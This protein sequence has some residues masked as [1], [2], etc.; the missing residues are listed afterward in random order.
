MTLDSLWYLSDSVIKNITP[1]WP[2]CRDKGEHGTQHKLGLN[3]YHLNQLADSPLTRSGA[4]GRFGPSS[5]FFSFYG[6]NG[7]P[8]GFCRS[9]D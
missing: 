7:F 4:S 9:M 5:F 3:K 2:D 6:K 8:D 1:N